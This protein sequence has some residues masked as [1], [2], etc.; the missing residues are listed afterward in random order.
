MSFFE[1]KIETSALVTITQITKVTTT[2]PTIENT[3]PKIKNTSPTIKS[4]SSMIKYTHVSSITGSN[5]R[6]NPEKKI[7]TEN[8]P[9]ESILPSKT[10]V[11]TEKLSSDVLKY[12]KAKQVCFS[13]KYL[14]N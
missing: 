9:I 6:Q 11:I 1:K 5:A 4:P 14:T 3:S 7:E 8:T 2:S 13:I 10:L 12:A